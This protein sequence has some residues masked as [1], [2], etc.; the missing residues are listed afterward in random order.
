MT[1]LMGSVR[2]SLN[3][4]TLDAAPDEACNTAGASKTAQRG[5]GAQ[6]YTPTGTSRSSTPKVRCDRL[7]DF[8]GQGQRAALTAL[9]ANSQMS[10]L[11]VDRIEFK[12]YHF[13][14]TQT[15]T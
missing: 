2:W 10:R 9:A 6:K 4:G 5:S 11:P 1:K 3:T 7:T 15:Q 8:R 12:R 13:A 14:C